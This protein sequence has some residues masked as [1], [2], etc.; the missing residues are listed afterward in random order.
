ML[1]AHQRMDIMNNYNSYNLVAQLG[2]LALFLNRGLGIYSFLYAGVISA[3]ISPLYLVWHCRRLGVLP[4]AGEWGRLTRQK[5]REVFSFGLD[6]FLFGLGGQLILSSQTIIVSRCLGLDLAAVWAV[7]TKV[8][9]FCLP[10]VLRPLYM[11][12]PALAEM[13]VRQERERLRSR[14]EGLVVLTGSLGVYLGISYA[15]CNSLFVG[16]WT[17]GRITWWAGNDGLLAVWLVIISI[18]SVHCN[19][20]LVAKQIGGIRYI[21]FAEGCCFVLLAGFWG[22][23]WGVPGLVSL[24]ILCTT[25]FSFQY[26][27]RRSLKYFQMG[28][29]A[30]V[31]RWL[32]PGLRLAL[33]YGVLAVMVW[34]ATKQLTPLPRLGVHVVVALVPGLFLFLRLGCRPETVQELSARLPGP[35]NKWLLFIAAAA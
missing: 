25:A 33:A 30:A 32:L 9:N 17:H 26:G 4:Q 12:M 34:L 8:F 21:F 13:I 2:L 29:G 6:V 5:F 31:S 20:T 27:L 14:F 7:G 19:L 28:V 16:L 24:S 10:L 3:V 18:Q 15:L 1:D 35:A 11:S 23:R 22:S